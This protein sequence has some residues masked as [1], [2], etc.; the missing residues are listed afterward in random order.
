MIN[1]INN[2]CGIGNFLEVLLISGGVRA[3]VEV[4]NVQPRSQGFSFSFPISKGKALGTRLG[5]SRNQGSW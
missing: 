3:R 4:G 1:W 2:S 5:L